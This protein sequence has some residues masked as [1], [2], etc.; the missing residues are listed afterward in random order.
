M[1][2]VKFEFVEEFSKPTKAQFQG[3]FALNSSPLAVILNSRQGKMPCGQDRWVINTIQAAKYAAENGLTV[4]TSVGLNTWEM[5]IWACSQAGARQT[6]IC[7]TESDDDRRQHIDKITADFN[8]IPEKT[9]W[10]FYQTTPKARS[11]KTDW[12]RR[13]KLA[14]ETAGVLIPVS[15]RPGGN[16][17]RMVDNSRGKNI[18]TDFKTKY[19][20]QS[21]HRHDHPNPENISQTITDL[22]WDYICHWTRANHGPWPEQL[23]AEYYKSI[24]ESNHYPNSG[25]AALVNII[26]GKRI[27]GSSENIRENNSAI[28]F[29]SLHPKEMLHLMTWRKRYVRYNFE[30]YGIAISRKMAASIGMRPVIYGPA[31]LYKRLADSDKPFFQNEGGKGGDWRPENEWRYPGD[32][33]L[34]QIPTDEL[35]VIV[36]HHAEIEALRQH[37]DWRVAAFSEGD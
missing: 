11:S 7:P 6:I 32:L 4:I 2:E 18:I 23:R 31:S 17:E 30:P 16:L 1:T 13:D 25:L 37:G 35:L 22:Q 3:N 21:A 29:S 9:G 36:R 10:L 26:R 8:L 24:A 28:A 5:A 12:P 15:L 27:C 34:S 33:D 20:A 19:E 14:I